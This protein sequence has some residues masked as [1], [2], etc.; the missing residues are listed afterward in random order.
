MG[1]VTTLAARMVTRASTWL[2]ST[3]IAIV[4]IHYSKAGSGGSQQIP[5]AGSEPAECLQLYDPKYGARK[6]AVAKGGA[7]TYAPIT[8]NVGGAERKEHS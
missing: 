7:A 6:M 5:G 3:G 2:W 8:P 4:G 1:M